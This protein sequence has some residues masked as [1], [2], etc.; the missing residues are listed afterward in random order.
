MENDFVRL[1][2]STDTF[3]DRLTAKQRHKVRTLCY[4]FFKAGKASQKKEPKKSDETS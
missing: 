3:V 1:W 2:L 4:R